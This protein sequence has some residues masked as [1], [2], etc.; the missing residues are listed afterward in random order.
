M[1]ETFNCSYNY[2]TAIIEISYST[3]GSDRHK[4]SNRMKA[5]PKT[6][7]CQK[8]NNLSLIRLDWLYP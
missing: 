6:T 4:W 5:F 3:S 1:S 7:F 2:I 8:I